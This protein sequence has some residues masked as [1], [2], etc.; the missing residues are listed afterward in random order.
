MDDDKLRILVVDDRPR[1][2]QVLQNTLGLLGDGVR[3]DTATNYGEALR[4]IHD[5]PYDLVTI[6]LLLRGETEDP[7][8]TE[9]QGMSL[10]REL[11]NSRYNSASCGLIVLT[12]YPS[13]A[14]TRQALKEFAA[15]DF[16]DKGEFDEEPFLA[17]ARAAIRGARL[18]R[19]AGRAGARYR[20]TITLGRG[21]ILGCELAGP[22]RRSSYNVARQ[23]EIDQED[24]ARRGD[25]L[26]TLLLQPGGASVWRPEARSIGDALFNALAEDRRVLGDLVAARALADRFSDLAIQFSGPSECLGLPFELLR[27]NDDHLGLKHMLTRRLVIAGGSSSRKPESFAGF[28]EGLLRR[29][30]PLRVLVVGANSDGAIP[31]AEEEAAAV[32]A[33]IPADLDR[34]GVRHELTTLIDAEASFQNVSR[35]LRGGRFHLFHYAGHGRHSD[36]LPEVGGLVLRDEGG[37][38]TLTASDLN[39]LARDSELQMVY[40]S[41]CLGARTAT[42]AGRGEFHGALEALA[43]ADVPVVLGFRWVVAD[44]PAHEL[45][46]RYYG[47]LWRCL[48]PA[49]ALLEARRA[50]AL[51]PK[52]RDDETWA[53]PVLLAQNG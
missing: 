43:R 5:R 53:S 2:Q 34:L 25:L 15:D 33:A 44:A 32:A 46:L 13:T 30:E 27:D 12:A 38:T 23:V 40:L 8:E 16:L 52:G 4:Q 6:D 36:K 26:N 9:T 3:V 11:R 47:A 10:L 18:R 20:L 51:G 50:A 22:D 28:L 19:A 37:L 49:E 45:A 14:R 42:Q 29:N 31:A 35:A 48:S 21:Q 39:L 41:C 7:G 24:L 17:A 1:W